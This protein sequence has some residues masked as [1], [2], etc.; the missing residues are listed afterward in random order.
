MA[1]GLHQKTIPVDW[2]E[3]CGIHARGMDSTDHGAEYHFTVHQAALFYLVKN[4]RA[5]DARLPILFEGDTD[6]ETS[7]VLVSWPLNLRPGWDEAVKQYRG[8]VK[9]QRRR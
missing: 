3:N 5:D 4:L 8:S 1:L 7:E 9:R 2:T 6:P